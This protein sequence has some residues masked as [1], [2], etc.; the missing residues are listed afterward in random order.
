MPS[1]D[2]LFAAKLASTAWVLL[3][4][5]GLAPKGARLNFFSFRQALPS[6]SSGGVAFFLLFV[7]RI[8]G[9]RARRVCA[10][11]SSSSISSLQPS[12][13]LRSRNYL[14]RPAIWYK[15]EALPRAPQETARLRH[16]PCDC[17][18]RKAASHTR[19][20]PIYFAA[21]SVVFKSK[22]IPTCL[23]PQLS[24]ILVIRDVFETFLL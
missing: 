13:G 19:L 7:G 9:I 5:Q 1:L 16:W 12:A 18:G 21:E 15:A 6:A 24:I 23:R 11:V 22:R 20:F 4:P 2:I 3:L 17:G 8:P 10:H 14:V